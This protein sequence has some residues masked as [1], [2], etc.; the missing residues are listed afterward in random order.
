MATKGPRSD[1]EGK[2]DHDWDAPPPYELHSS[3]SVLA[4]SFAVTAD[5]RLN[6]EFSSTAPQ[7]LE[8]L[9]PPVPTPQPGEAQAE[10]RCPTLNIVIQVVGSRGDVQ[11]FIALG[12]ALRKYGHRVRLATHDTFAKFVGES[13]LEF[14][15]IGGDPE[16]LMAYMVKNPGLIPC[17]ESLKGGDIP[18]KRKMISE[19]LHGCWQSCIQPDPVSKNPFV[20][21]AI[22]ANPPSFAHIH[23]GQALGIPVHIMFTMPA[24]NIN[25]KAC[26]YLSYGV[27][28]LMTWQGLGDVINGWR[29]R[30]L[31]LEPLAASMALVPRPVDWDMRIDV[32]G[33]FLREP[34]K[35]T[36][37]DDIVTFLAAGPA[38]L[39]VGFGSIVLEDPLRIT[40]VIKEA[41]IEA[42]VRVII[43]RGWSNLGGD[44]PATDD[45]LYIGDCPHEW[46][47]QHVTAVV[48]HGGA[49]TTACG[50][51]HARPTLIVPFFGDQPFWGDVVA[52]RGA[53]P[54]P[55]ASNKLA[56]QNLTEAI[57][58]CLTD[59][60]K[61]AAQM[62]AD[63]MRHDD[64]VNSAYA[65][66]WV[67]SK[68][69]SLKLSNA[70][71]KVL[72]AQNQLSLSDVEPYRPRQYDTQV[73]R[74]DP[75][76]AGA[77]SVLGIATEFTSALGGTFVDPYKEF[78]RA[79]SNGVDS[80]GPAALAAGK[81]LRNA[82]A[83][84]GDQP[85]NHGKVTDWKSG[86]A[87][88]AK[89]F[90][91][92]FYQG[93]T[94]IVTKPMEGAKKEGTV[95]LLKGLGKG[96]IEMVT[97][98]G[99]AMFGVLAYPAQGIYKSIR[100]WDRKAFEHAV[101]SQK[102]SMFETDRIQGDAV[103][104]VTRFKSLMDK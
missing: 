64:G 18:R 82:P 30:E 40:R 91:A 76:T 47:F 52:A 96:S 35:Y 44:S 45:V 8:R 89:N 93:I 103:E 81:G 95:G 58:Y 104:V 42:G 55:I 77:S 19:M 88:A 65:A 28:D 75:L 20:A 21:D 2:G 23:C 13:G 5:G 25:P 50:L 84:Y 78:R 54:K 59:E 46:L 43:S 51:Y 10:I 69:R 37:P 36:P 9:L 32:C 68:Q 41:C 48:H 102:W 62:V 33:F 6:V 74:W 98:P 3:G 15:P 83:L 87:V 66:S 57:M 14:Y 101:E 24:E 16:D 80:S 63:S 60:A 67:Y 97:K 17:V 61:R 92:G 11:P 56:V 29:R 100:S 49:G 31:F 12:T 73:S 4:S 90:G 94:G 39:Y 99:S 70:A 22:I 34:P 86:G 1:E 26:N 79:R 7:E 72:V 85:E 38:P 71:L 27:V 53:G